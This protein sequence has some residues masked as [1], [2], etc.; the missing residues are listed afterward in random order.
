M[1]FDTV[2]G[3]QLFFGGVQNVGVDGGAVGYGNTVECR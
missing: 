1:A 2:A 3:T